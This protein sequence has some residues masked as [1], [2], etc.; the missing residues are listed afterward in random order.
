MQTKQEKRRLDSRSLGSKRMTTNPRRRPIWAA[1]AVVLLGFSTHLAAQQIA[2]EALPDGPSP[3]NQTAQ[4]KTSQTAASI[5][6]VVIDETGAAITTATVRLTFREPAHSFDTKTDADGGFT[7]PNPGFGTFVISVA[8]PGF[9]AISVPGVVSAGQVFTL[10]PVTLAAGSSSEVD[11]V[12][13]TREEMAQEQ[14]NVETK[15]RFLGVIPNYYMSYDPHPL[16][17]SPKQKFELATKFTLDPVSF[18]ITGLTAAVQQANG[19]YSGFGPGA[20]GYGKRYAAATGTFL[21]SSLLGGALLPSIFHQD[22]RYFYKGTGSIKSRTLYAIAN[23]V[24]CKGDNGRW[25]FNYSGIGGGLAAGAI[26]NFYYPSKDRDGVE[27]TF[28][29]LAIGLAEESAANIAQEFLF[30]KLTSHTQK[31]KATP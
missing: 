20:G 18:G 9:S 27:S 8:A 21:N 3:Q 16:P 14:L 7:F 22:P 6:G 31:A 12:G 5:S 24:I 26:S 11:V 10:P 17:L 13:V 15:Q 29:N 30:R 4:S 1:G 23:T 2:T 28:V 25:Q 19:D